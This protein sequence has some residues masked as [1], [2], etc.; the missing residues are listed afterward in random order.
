[1]W[2]VL[3]EEHHHDQA[4]NHHTNTCRQDDAGDEVFTTKPAA[5]RELQETGGGE[6]EH[7][8]YGTHNPLRETQKHNS[9]THPWMRL[10]AA[11]LMLMNQQLTFSSS[12]KPRQSYESDM[13][14]AADMI[15]KVMM[16]CVVLLSSPLKNTLE[17]TWTEYRQHQ[18]TTNVKESWWNT[19]TSRFTH[20][21]KWQEDCNV[22]NSEKVNEESPD[23]HQGVL[24]ISMCYFSITEILL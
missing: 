14:V 13:T 2:T 4:D 24:H 7:E 12:T 17:I 21:F 6:D 3:R 20:T 10:T 22:R 5:V 16:T 15:T 19:R 18:E 23:L 9:Y 1:M 11:S 8:R